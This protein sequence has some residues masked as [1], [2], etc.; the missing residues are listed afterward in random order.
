MIHKTAEVSSK[1]KIGKNVKIWHFS[2]IREDVQIGDSCIIGA[3]VYID[4]EV[5]I[6]SNVK[7]QNNAL[8]YFGTTIENDVFIGPSVILTNDKYP[9]STTSAGKLKR[10]KDWRVGKILVQHGASIGA[11]S[12]ILPDIAIGTYSLIGAGSNVTKTVPAHALVV[13]NPARIVG[14]VCKNGHQLEIK[15]KKK[16][17][18]YQCKICGDKNS[19]LL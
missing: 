8:I 13:G 4:Y 6:G 7:V 18:N 9:R 17:I 19:I 14:Y 16:N 3:N 12:I 10:A 1:A 5:K 11:G 15:S 2:I